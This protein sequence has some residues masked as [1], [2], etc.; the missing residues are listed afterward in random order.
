M[1]ATL[2]K[3]VTISEKVF[4]LNK[5]VEDPFITEMVEKYGSASLSLELH[6]DKR[7]KLQDVTYDN[8]GMAIINIRCNIIYIKFC[9]LDIGCQGN[10]FLIGDQDKSKHWTSSIIVEG[11]CEGTFFKGRFKGN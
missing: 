10:E 2:Y 7:P 1:L 9:F 4:A 6:L 11:N 5:D 3:L 8:I